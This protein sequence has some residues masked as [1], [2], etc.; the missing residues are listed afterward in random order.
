VAAREDDV[1]GVEQLA[2]ELEQLRR[3]EAEIGELVHAVVDGAGGRHVAREGQHHRRVVPAH[4]RALLAGEEGVEQLGESRF[5]LGLAQRLGEGRGD[6]D[7]PG[8]G[9]GAHAQSGLALGQRRFGL[10]PED[11][12]P[13]LGEAAHQVL[14]TL[15]DEI[16]PQVGKANQGL[17]FAKLG[18]VLALPQLR[19]GGQ[20]DQRIKPLG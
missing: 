18:R 6:D 8:L 20:V 5:A 7:D 9:A 12:P 19:G 16:P 15:K 4:E 11:H 17:V 1:R 10:L 13:R 14:G 2:L 3:R